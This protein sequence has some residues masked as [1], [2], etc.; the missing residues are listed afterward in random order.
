MPDTPEGTDATIFLS[1]VH[2]DDQRAEGRI[3]KMAHDIV[4]TYE[5][6]TGRKLKLFIDRDSIVWGEN[7]RA[8]LNAEIERT[9][10]LLPVVTPRFLKSVACREEVI[11]FTTSLE[12]SEA[13]KLLLPL[14]WVDV[15]DTDIVPDTDPVLTKLRDAQFIDVTGLRTGSVTGAAYEE[16]LEQIAMRLR[17]S[18]Q[19]REGMGAT[20]GLRAAPDGPEEG[21]DLV[22]ALEKFQ[23]RQPEFEQAF[24]RFGDAFT[25]LDQ[26]FAAAEPPSGASTGAMQH[27]LANLGERLS[28]PVDTL[29]SATEAFAKAWSDIEDTLGRATRLS[30]GVLAAETSADLRTTLDDLIRSIDSVALDD[31][32]DQARMM[33]NVSRHLRP[34]SRALDSAVRVI[35]G[36]RTSVVTMRS[37]L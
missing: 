24:A 14:V 2:A 16:R 9:V 22:T 19:L 32:R 5:Y 18:V 35:S 30:S 31:M 1:Y 8:R 6:L 7:W 36:I 33:G 23:E 17:D 13:K 37:H 3:V 15:K 21:D 29:S 12:R 10:F 28:K 11:H 27:A 25:E 26:A 20:G 4:D 34:L